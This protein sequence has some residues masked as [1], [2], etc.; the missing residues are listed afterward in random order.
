M[1]QRWRRERGDGWRRKALVNGVGGLMTAVVVAVVAVT[2]FS[3]GAWMVIAV[4]PIAVALMLGIR[5][6]YRSLA[7]ALALPPGAGM[8]AVPPPPQV[9]VA[10]GRINRATLAAVTFARSISPDVRAVYVCENVEQAIAYRQRWRELAPEVRLDVVE[11]PYRSLLSPLLAYIDA[12]DA[13]RAG[14]VTVVLP[15]FV[16][17]HW[18]EFLLH[19]FTAL[20]LKLGLFFRP[21]TIVIDLPYHVGE[22]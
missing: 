2:K 19:N 13:E 18:W 3:H 9:V 6:H 12:V 8:P 10:V 1:V 11:S 16:P 15:E 14:P 4:I 21:N 7:E 22:E 5:H 20:R 17:R